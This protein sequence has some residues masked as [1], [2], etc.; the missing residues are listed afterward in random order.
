MNQDPP[1]RGGSFPWPPVAS[2]A[3]MRNALAI[4]E[5]WMALVYVMP[6][7]MSR[8]VAAEV[9]R[10][11]DLMGYVHAILSVRDDLASGRW[12]P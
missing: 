6:P 10:R 1:Y 4:E 5:A 2:E 12:Q 8:E 7:V 11:R 3:A 9:Q